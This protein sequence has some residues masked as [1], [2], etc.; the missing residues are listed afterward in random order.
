MIKM[1]KL[2]MINLEIKLKEINGVLRKCY[3][4]DYVEYDIEKLMNSSVDKANLTEVIN[5]NKLNE[6]EKNVNF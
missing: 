4:I 3:Y 1:D 6:D 2:Y 5:S